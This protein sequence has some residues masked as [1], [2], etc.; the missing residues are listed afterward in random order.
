MQGNCGDYEGYE[1][2]SIKCI[3]GHKWMPKYQG[4]ILRKLDD[5]V[6]GWYLVSQCERC[7]NLKQQKF[8]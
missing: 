7:G 3:F 5:H 6:I 8:T 1:E 4:N 2:M